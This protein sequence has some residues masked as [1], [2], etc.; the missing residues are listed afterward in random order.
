MKWSP[1]ILDDC[2]IDQP[3][4]LHAPLSLLS[5]DSDATEVLI[6]TIVKS[7]SDI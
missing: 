4:C 2:E 3:F 5:M 7:R 6:V 1:G